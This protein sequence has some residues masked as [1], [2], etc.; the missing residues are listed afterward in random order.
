Q[1]LSDGDYLAR[2]A[3]WDDGILVDV[4]AITWCSGTSGCEAGAVSFSNSLIGEHAND[5]IGSGP[6]LFLENGRYVILSPDW[7]WGSITN[8]GA[9]T[10]CSTSGCTGHITNT[11]SLLGS[12]SGDQ[13]GWKGIRLY[14]SGDY[15][16][17]S[18]KWDHDGIADIGAAT[19]CND[20]GGCAGEI[21]PENSLVGSQAGDGLEM[22]AVASFDVN[23][24]M[25]MFPDWDN[26]A[27]IN[28]GAVKWCPASGGCA[29]E[30]NAE[31]SLR[32]SNANDQVGLFGTEMG[33]G[34]YIL[35][36]YNWNG[37]AAAGL[38]AV[39]FC[40]NPSG[41]VGVVSS[42]NSL[43]GSVG[44]DHVGSGSFNWNYDALLYSHNYWHYGAAA[45][46]G[47]L[48]FCKF[49]DLSSCSGPVST[50]NSLIGTHA[51]DQ[52]GQNFQFLPSGDYVVAS[53]Q[54]N[55]VGAI[56]FCSGGSGCKGSISTENSLTGSSAGDQVGS[57]WRILENG[58]Y[59]V[60]SPY[61]NNGAMIDAGAVTLCNAATGCQGVI[62]AT[63]SLVGTT[64]YDTLGNY[65]LET[66]TNNDYLVHNPSWDNGNII[67]AGNVAWCDGTSGC[68][69]ALASF[70]RSASG[71][72]P[73]GGFYMTYAF[74][75]VNHQI[76]VGRPADNIVTVLAQT[77]EYEIFLPV[78]KR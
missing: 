5:Q 22:D 41:C 29:G 6:T 54:W 70:P 40:T 32:G 57:N 78:I 14:Y 23:N 42:S 49:N 2:S 50:A 68:H 61:W 47:A 76:V 63:N 31:S 46:A 65:G 64:A 28:A 16:I 1:I 33:G 13:V 75:S 55:D 52:V 58:N 60:S 9:A 10:W 45:N 43:V 18:P 19:W 37:G 20:A 25:V 4:G 48:T 21:T 77:I 7:D 27:T 17:L 72:S 11:N 71:T 69:G 66:L 39:T 3:N 44:G 12:A 15:L 51:N 56:T 36:N 26:G 30:V 67:D 62:S 8:A 34:K 74:D 73:N 35:S 38:G 24:Y 59:V 53:S